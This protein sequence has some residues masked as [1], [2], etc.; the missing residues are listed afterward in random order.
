MCV[1]VRALSLQYSPL[2]FSSSFYTW[3]SPRCRQTDA[4]LLLFA[5]SCYC[6][7]VLNVLVP[8]VLDSN[9]SF[10]F[11]IL[12]ATQFCSQLAAGFFCVCVRNSKKGTGNN[13][14]AVKGSGTIAGW[15][16]DC[17]DLEQPMGH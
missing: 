15:L 1:Q 13:K 2:F 11:Y 4:R 12:A 8:S 9:P 6:C 3:W 17:I 10:P 14:N 16:L 7:A 5:S